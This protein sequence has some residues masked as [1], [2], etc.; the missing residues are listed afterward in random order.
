VPTLAPDGLTYCQACTNFL[1]YLQGQQVDIFA[2]YKAST[3]NGRIHALEIVFGIYHVENVRR[4]GDRLDAIER[5]A[6]RSPST[7]SPEERLAPFEAEYGERLHFPR[8]FWRLAAQL[9]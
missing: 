1:G 5:A 6:G 8:I 3:L 4:Y 9:N 7:G 2:P